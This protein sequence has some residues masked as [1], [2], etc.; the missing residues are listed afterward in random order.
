MGRKRR[1]ALE[2][3]RLKYLPGYDLIRNVFRLHNSPQRYSGIYYQLSCSHDNSQVQDVVRGIFGRVPSRSVN[4]DEA[5][6]IGAAIQGGVLAGNVTDVLLLDVTPLS[7]GIETLGGVFTRLINRNTTIPTKKGQVGGVKEWM[8]T[9]TCVASTVVYDDL[10]TH[11]Y[12]YRNCACAVTSL[13]V[14]IAL[15]AIDCACTAHTFENCKV[16]DATA[17]AQFWYLYCTCE[18]Q[19][20]CKPL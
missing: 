9:S 2:W 5:V 8:N 14:A 6:A 13:T 15:S 10:A 12:E 16:S 4:P 17:H 11:G 1:T 19:D 3:H 18:L 7:L 20:H